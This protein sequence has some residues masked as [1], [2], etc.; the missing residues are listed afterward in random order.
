MVGTKIGSWTTFIHAALFVFGFSITF[1]VGWGGA[2]TLVGQVFSQYKLLLSQIG[3]LVVIL[4]GLFHMGVLRLPLLNYDIRPYWNSERGFGAFSSVLMGVFFAAGW[5]PC[6]GTTLGAILT[7]GFSQETTGQAMVLSSGYAIGLGTPFLMIG[8]GINR[9]TIVLRRFRKHSRTFQV[10]NG[11]ML[12]LVGL[13]ML[14]NQ[15]YVIASWATRNGL[16]LDIS[17]GG[18]TTP[19]YLIAVLAGFLSFLSPCVLPLVPAYM[20]YLSGRGTEL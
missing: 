7:L 13:L 1:I 2:F 8:I 17:S 4:L 12:I 5:T 10:V 16:Y 3:G 11:L 14:T 6:I 20:G 9:A 18:I 15:L 19:T